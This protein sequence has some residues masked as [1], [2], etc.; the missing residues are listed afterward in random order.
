MNERQSLDSQIW[1]TRKGGA[2]RGPFPTGMV[3]RFVLLGRLDEDSDVSPDREAWFRLG[4][5][6]RLVPEELK[7]LETP[8]DQERLLRARLREDERRRDRRHDDDDA[9]RER[10]RGSDRRGPEPEILVV[11]R[12]ARERELEHTAAAPRRSMVLAWSILGV[13][14]GGLL[15]AGIYA[16][17]SAPRG[18]EPV[19]NCDASAAPEVDWGNCSLEGAKLDGAALMGARIDNA[20]LHSAALRGADLT[21]SNLAYSN[22][23]TADLRY[24]NLSHA[25]L[26]G[27]GLR[28]ADLRNAILRQADL[29]YADLRGAQIGGADLEGARLDKAIWID[30]RVCAAGSLGDCR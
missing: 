19:R 25:I 12:A 4:D 13:V 21:R 28:S 23:S 24:A 15:I 22:L 27:T 30:G 7:H 1:Y 20:D 9:G 8:E 26:L 11:R 6:E 18:T 29:S 16:G 3:R 17:M 14:L 5:I 2:V 10:R